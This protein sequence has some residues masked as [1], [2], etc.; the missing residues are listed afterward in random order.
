MHP[1]CKVSPYMV[2]KQAFYSKKED[3][4]LFLSVFFYKK[5]FACVCFNKI[6]NFKFPAN[7]LPLSSFSLL[8]IVYIMLFLNIIY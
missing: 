2:I 3:S 5:H 4:F 6:Q 1:S 7:N 8:F